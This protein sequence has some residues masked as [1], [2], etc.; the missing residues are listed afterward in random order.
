MTIWYLYMI[1]CGDDSL[2]TGITTDVD[3]RFSEHQGG[4]PRAARYLK[5]RGPLRLMLKLNAGS[6]ES[7]LKL[8]CRIKGL[9]R[10]RKET[11]IRHPETL[12]QIIGPPRAA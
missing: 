7:A 6:R 5:G 1:R 10:V 12:Q 3:R 2:Y 8:E 4:G 11:L 9:S